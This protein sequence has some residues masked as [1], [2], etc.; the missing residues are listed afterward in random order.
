MEVLVLF[1]VAVLGAVDVFHSQ[2]TIVTWT[3]SCAGDHSTIVD[4]VFCVE[5][6][7]KPNVPRPTFPIV[8]RSIAWTDLDEEDDDR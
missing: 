7:G 2:G 3:L 1:P 4:E 5:E 6:K 8:L